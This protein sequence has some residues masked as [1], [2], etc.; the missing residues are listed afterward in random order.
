MSYFPPAPYSY[1]CDVR[2]GR[3]AD[4]GRFN[5]LEAYALQRWRKSRKPKHYS[6]WQRTLEAIRRRKPA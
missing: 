2:R 4:L 1:I 5:R 6:Y 3:I